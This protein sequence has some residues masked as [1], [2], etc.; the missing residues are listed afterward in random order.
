MIIGAGTGNDVGIALSMGAEHVDAVE[1]DPALYELGQ[2]RHPDRPYSST[3]VTAIIDDGRAW[4][5]RSEGDYDVIL[6]ALPD[7][8]TLVSGASSLR[9]ESFLFT[10]E[11]MDTARDLLAPDGVFAMYNF[12]REDW[13]ID[14]LAATLS[15]SFGN[16]PCV[17]T[18]GGGSGLALLAVGSEPLPACP[19]ATVRD[20]A[21]A[22]PPVT[23]DY[24][25]VYIQTRGIPSLYLVALA[26]LLVVS[27]LAIRATGTS[28]RSVGPNLDLFLMGVAFLLLETKSVVQFALWFGTTWRVN[29]LVFTGVLLSV[30][31]AIEVTRLRRLPP[32]I[33]LYSILLASVAASWAVPAEVLLDLPGLARFV[34][35]VVIT[36]TPI[37]IAN[38][39]FAQRFAVTGDSTAAFGVN[40]LGAMVGGVLEYSSLLIGYRALAILVGILYL[41]A[42]LAWRRVAAVQPSLD[43]R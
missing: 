18:P 31:A 9:L 8:L 20:I 2:A 15:A 12:Y 3:R 41:G 6:F 42:F 25:F 5:E 1:I 43:L 38:L 36:F 35:A 27:V 10:Q 22:P 26:S 19:V 7:S 14:R 34:L 11:A 39:V 40:L 30:L 24:P 29:A 37:F 23:D 21:T 13:L 32:P 33:V 4:M 17:L 28:L 16:D